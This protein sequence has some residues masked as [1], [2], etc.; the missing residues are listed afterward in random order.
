[1][2]D[3]FRM[4]FEKPNLSELN[5]RYTVVDM[6]FHSKHSDGK[7]TVT[8]IADQAR[9]LGIGIAITDHNCIAAAVEIDKHEDVF[10][11]PG[12]EITSKEGSHLL[13]YFYDIDS[14]KKFNNLHIKPH[15]GN[16]V[17][18]SISLGM[19]EIIQSAR[20]FNTLIVFPHPYCAVYTGINN[21]YFSENRLKKM[22]ET[23]D[24]VEVINAGN[25]KKWNLKS[26]VLG[27]NLNK[28]ITGGSDGHYLKQMGRVVSYA[29]CK[30]DRKEFLDAVKQKKNRVIGKEFDMLRKVTT[31]GMK[32]KSNFK[33]YPDLVEKNIK[34]SYNLINLKSKTLKDNV[35][36][37]LNEKIK[38]HQT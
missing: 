34:Y 32:L 31:N 16:E 8:E 7:N 20:A 2:N 27:F 17:M 18:S 10:S 23:V 29:E 13:V 11:I 6:H 1:M 33:N 14:L 21:S 4:Y 9:H 25:L 36:R 28:A 22:Y 38:G 15:M 35:K 19:E 26:A 5:D 30:R 3:N 37:R 12:I 24:G